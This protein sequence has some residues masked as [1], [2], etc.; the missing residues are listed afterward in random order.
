M[1]RVIYNFPG[2]ES[3]TKEDSYKTLAEQIDKNIFNVI[4]RDAGIKETIS[5]ENFLQ[6]LK[7]K[8]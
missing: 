2:Y 6:E 5:S 8:G 3:P 1:S 7:K 4:R